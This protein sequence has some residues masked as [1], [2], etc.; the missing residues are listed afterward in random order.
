MRF[1]RHAIVF[2]AVLL[3]TATLIA[4][5]RVSGLKGTLSDPNSNPIP[6]ATVVLTNVEARTVYQ[7]TS[8]ADGSYALSGLPAGRYDLVIP[9]IGFTFRRYER[10]G[11][12]LEPGQVQ[13]LDI[14][15]EWGGNLGT[16]GDDFT[17]QIRGRNSVPSGPTPRTAD[18]K[19]DFTGVWFG[20]PP[21]TDPATALPWA[22]AIFKERA[23]NQGKDHPSGF[24][25]PGDVVL[26]SAFLYK[27][28]QTPSEIVLLWEGNLPGVDQIFL[29]GRGH[30]ANFDPSWMG[31][32]VGRWDGDTLVVDT[33]G[34]N[35]RSWLGLFPHT[36][37]LHVVQ[38]YSRPDLGHLEKEITIEDPATF[39]K[40][41]QQHVKWELA[42]AEEIHE[43]ICESNAYP[44]H[45]PG[46]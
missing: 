25:L 11:I 35:D 13:R 31:H 4:Q 28:V 16:I 30:P 26:Q 2:F 38:R 20:L 46:K 12:M 45:R 42:P 5:N 34:F 41:W 23:A 37:K 44:Q 18:G 3:S 43:L 14:K 1:P 39:V 27:L 19:P 9:T 7:A 17:F 15:F 22:D 33:V 40:P 8:A 10:K 32:S 24:C 6:T 21:V 29:D 36:E